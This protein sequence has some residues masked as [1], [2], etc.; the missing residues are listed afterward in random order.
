MSCLDGTAKRVD[1]KCQA[2]FELMVFPEHRLHTFAHI[3]LLGVVHTASAWCHKNGHS[4]VQY[5]YE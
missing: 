1:N 4:Q 2:A 3:K 5:C